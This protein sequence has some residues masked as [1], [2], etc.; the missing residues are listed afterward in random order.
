[1]SKQLRLHAP[2]SSPAPAAIAQCHTG[3]LCLPKHHTNIDDIKKNTV[4][5]VEAPPKKS[6]QRSNIEERDQCLERAVQR[7]WKGRS[8]VC[9][10]CTRP[11][12]LTHPL[13]QPPQ[14]LQSTFP[15]I[16]IILKN[17]QHQPF[18]F[19]LHQLNFWLFNNCVGFF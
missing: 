16:S 1:V 15:N 7:S 19:C 2:P 4:M 18:F 13:S 9:R 6:N 3:R 10:P 17:Q 8:P 14:C 5:H 12:T 11:T